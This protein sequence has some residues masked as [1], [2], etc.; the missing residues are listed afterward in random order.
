ME[1]SEHTRRYPRC[2]D[3][4]GWKT[5]GAK[6]GGRNVWMQLN[7]LL[8]VQDDCASEDILVLTSDF[9]CEFPIVVVVN[10]HNCYVQFAP[11]P[12]I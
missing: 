1:G 11:Y 9:T 8:V 2:L 6:A 12:Y 3:R 4:K 7:C 10:I 5:L